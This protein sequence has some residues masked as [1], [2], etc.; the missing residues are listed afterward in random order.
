[1]KGKNALLEGRPITINDQSGKISVDLYGRSGNDELDAASVRMLHGFDVQLKNPELLNSNGWKKGSLVNSD[2]EKK[3]LGEVKVLDYP[4]KL[5]T[6][7]LGLV[8]IFGKGVEQHRH[9]HAEYY[10]I[11]EGSGE[12]EL[13][14]RKG[15]QDGLETYQLAEGRFFHIPSRMLHALKAHSELYVVVYSFSSNL[16]GDFGA[17][18]RLSAILNGE[19]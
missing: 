6:S 19:C 15:G 17:G 18:H 5:N 7:A 8:H 16:I 3:V 1:M 11:P 2:Y 13:S 12:G 4:R 14:I 10:L 9:F